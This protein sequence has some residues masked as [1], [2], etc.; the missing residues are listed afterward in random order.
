MLSM[1]IGVIILAFSLG[2]I[3]SKYIYKLVVNYGESVID[4]D[5]LFSKLGI[6]ES[7]Y[8]A[9]DYNEYSEYKTVYF[10]RSGR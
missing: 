7:Q 4:P 6:D 10:K 2:T 3:S 8:E 1:K 9:S 5:Y